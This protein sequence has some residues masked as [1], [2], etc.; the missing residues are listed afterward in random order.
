M[1]I[2]VMVDYTIKYEINYICHFENSILISI[3]QKEE[4]RLYE[5]ECKCK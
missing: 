4:K 2:F 5:Q 3:E 1:F